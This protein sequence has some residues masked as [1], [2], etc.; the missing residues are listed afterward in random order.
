MAICA[1]AVLL[2][3]GLAHSLLASSLHSQLRPL[4]PTQ[5]SMKAHGC[6]SQLRSSSPPRSRNNVTRTWEGKRQGGGRD[7]SSQESSGLAGIQP[8]LKAVPDQVLKGC[9]FWPMYIFSHSFCNS[10]GDWGAGSQERKLVVSMKNGGLISPGFI[11]TAH[12]T[13]WPPDSRV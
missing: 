5:G 3:P 1:A 2:W 7:E 4:P 12:K 9:S 10:K 8:L 13:D 6:L 11:C